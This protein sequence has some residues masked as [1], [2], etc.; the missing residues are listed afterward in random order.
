MKIP[1]SKIE[2]GR[3]TVREKLDEEHV[4]ALAESLKED[5]Q[6]DPIIV[7]PKDGKYELIAG[8]YRLEAAK[9]LGWKEIEATVKD[10]SDEE[11]DFLA[12]KTNLMRKNMDEIEEAKIIK[13]IM[14]KYDLSQREIARKLGKSDTWVLRRLA[15]VLKI[16][17]KV[18]NALREGKISAEHAALIARI[19]EEMKEDWKQK[20]NQFLQ[21]I[22][23]NKWS[24]D[25]TRVQL[26][27]FLNDTIYTIG[28][29]GRNLDD[30][31]MLL[32]NNGIKYLIDVRYSNKSEK[33]PEFNG[34]ILERELKRNGV[35]YV[36]MPQLGLP[37]LIQDPYKAGA[38][39]FECVKQWYRWYVY[40]QNG[41]D[42]E[43]FVDEIKSKG[44]TALMCME[45]YSK[46]TRDQKIHCHR[47]I[48]ADMI[49]EIEKD[50]IKLF[51]NR[52]DL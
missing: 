33:K 18:Q 50:G 23:K 24:R 36:H 42:F 34:D 26:K 2:V 7:R 8:H 15:L 5:G 49:L 37:Y 51:E 14:D 17:D 48:L 45:R 9:Y 52:I 4:K 28:Y 39:S 41:F 22:L 11:A 21:L 30:F 29:Q 43:K 47:D 10:L 19:S 20:Q 27:R 16:T 44:K 32:K 40:N 3:Y 13:K 6:W 35:E 31:I 25:E 12:L 46:P 38:L 1:I